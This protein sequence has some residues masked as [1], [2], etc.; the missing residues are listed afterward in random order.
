MG[1]ST[2]LSLLQDRTGFL[3]VGTEA[4]LYRYEGLRFSIMGPKEGLACGAEVTGLYESSDGALW[5]VACSGLF[6]GENGRFEAV[7]PASKLS[8]SLQGITGD[9][10][11]HILLTSAQGLQQVATLRDADG[12]F[13]IQP[14]PLPRPLQNRAIR[15]LFRHGSTL[16]FGCDQ[17]L[18]AVDAGRLISYG[19][20]DGLPEAQ[21]SGILAL[22]NGE[23]WARSTELTYRRMP[24]QKRFSSVSPALPPS[25]FSGFIGTDQY[26]KILIPT[27]GGL[28]IGSA[29][30]FRL[31]GD[32][33]GLHTSMASVV[34]EDREGSLWVGLVGE[35]LARWV[36]RPEWES[37]TKSN[38]LPSKLVWSI[39]RSR[40]DGSLWVGTSRGIV[41]MASSGKQ[42]VWDQ[43][44]G[45]GS[46]VRWLGEARDGAIW[47]IMRPA[48][49]A[50]ID[51]RTGS[52]K[53]FSELSGLRAERIFRATFDHLGRLWV[54]TS[55]GLLRADRPSDNS[56][57]TQVTDFGAPTKAWDVMED[58]QGI[59]WAT[60]SEGLWRLSDGSWRIYTRKDGLLADAPYVIAEG[61]D[62]SLWLRHRH[63]GA[64]ERVEFSGN[65]IRTAQSIQPREQLDPTAF[66][67]FDVH[68]NFW[69]GTANGV[70]VLEDPNAKGHIAGDW[71]FFTEEDGLVANDCDGE[72][73]WAD[74]D[75][76]VWIGTSGGLSHYSPRSE[77][78]AV[79]ATVGDP[80]ITSV[81]AS[82]WP[83]AAHI[84]FSALNFKLENAMQFAYSLD[85]D[86]WVENKDRDISIAGLGP[87]DHRFLVRT[88]VAGHPW[89]PR[90]ASA[91]F[92]FDPFWWQ[93]WWAR[94][95]A[96]TLIAAVLTISVRA[97]NSRLRRK[98]RDRARMEEEKARAHA[99]SQ[100]KS[101]FLAHMSH[102][103][104]T[105]L[106]E[107]IGLTDILEGMPLPAVASESVRL[108]RSSGK[109]LMGVLN[110][111]LDFSKI[112]AGK[113]DL[114]LAPFDLRAC[115]R[116]SVGLFAKTAKDKSLAFTLDIH[117]PLPKCVVGDGTRLRQV[118]MSFISNA[119]KFTHQG[120][121]RVCA[122]PAK[123][124]GERQWLSFTVRDSGIGIPPDRLHSL[125]HPFTQVDASINRRYGGT[126]L[127]LTIAKS[128]V[129][130]MGG[131]VSVQSTVGV[132]SV[133][134]ILVPFLRAPDPV[135]MPAPK[136]PGA[137]HGPLRI[138]VAEDNA[139]NQ[140]IIL[141]LIERLG[142]SA[143]LA[144][145]G[146]EA[147]GAALGRPYDVIVMDVQMPRMD[148]LEA[149][150]EIRKQ[151][152]AGRQP[153][154]VALTAHATTD[155]RRACLEA[156][157]DDYFTK[158]IDVDALG[159][160]LR[161]LSGS[162]VFSPEPVRENFS[163]EPR[164]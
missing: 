79:Q 95:L 135:E 54:A 161:R 51:P 155:D 129:E 17:R 111:I 119:L 55:S 120:E 53:T 23:V 91:G 117:D 7:I 132:G 3:W 59:L 76:S 63:D 70:A 100:A 87:G 33:D 9:G 92:H 65:R 67:G 11:D 16:W 27:D 107:I 14:Y 18:C 143:D 140:R 138:L 148:G 22:D 128:L 97:W 42:T 80:V 71:R 44:V 40:S 28:A 156:G 136:E 157:M 34:M 125:F 45:L 142:Y 123:V 154:I 124:E 130:L 151:A 102:E 103:I 163:T 101:L 104:R 29:A 145:D 110:G 49:L 8:F 158:P 147:V 88:R 68:G 12:R 115:L 96:F 74:S 4:G 162:H 126:G 39:L 141:K 30:G 77:N 98:A 108:L 75:G 118:L 139:I 83:P 86:S 160:T 159:R 37:W 48:T 21:W 93:T 15:G 47:A 122:A 114:E 62:G 24:G 31:I 134:S 90:I 2:V 137:D 1:N 35:G 84:E 50:R 105:P 72:A 66:H 164:A 106:Q 6:R 38:G 144:R 60:S 52:V 19:V 150:R 69:Q 116:D 5:V 36:G 133:F 131:S 10:H 56:R 149:A 26:G 61:T 20:A 43:R 64:V 153:Y 109:G 46:N 146:A 121:I 57:F 127:G 113:L 112:E 81:R 78:S 94:T 85:G 73:F 82:S 152:L 89:S 32:A 99:A 13:P 41:R 25:Y 58:R